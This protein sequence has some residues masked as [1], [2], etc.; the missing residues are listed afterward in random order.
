MLNG[1]NMENNF[2]ENYSQNSQHV[3]PFE[4]ERIGFEKLVIAHDLS[5]SLDSIIKL[6]N[7]IIKQGTSVIDKEK[8]QEL[9]IHSFSLI[10]DFAT[11]YGVHEDNNQQRLALAKNI[12]RWI[13]NGMNPLRE[14]DARLFPQLFIVN[15]S[16]DDEVVISPEDT[17]KFYDAMELRASDYSKTSHAGYSELIDLAS[18]PLQHVNPFHADSPKKSKEFMTLGQRARNIGQNVLRIFKR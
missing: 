15:D 5:E 3:A 10:H 9:L 7:K 6:D 17:Q 11:A 14:L 16:G 18:D 1:V 13:V 4:T 8:E 2:S 12:D